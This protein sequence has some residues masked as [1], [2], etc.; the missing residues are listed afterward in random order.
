MMLL[1][2]LFGTS[3]AQ[4]LTPLVNQPPDGIVMTFQ[5]TDGTVMAQGNNY[6]DW[7]KLTPDNTGS[8]VNGSWTQL[9][10]SSCRI[11]TL[12]QCFRG[13]G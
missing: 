6:Y 8:Y 10:E 3:L 9:A 7:W 2:A 13:I 12:R 4:T 1:L 5:L 11:R